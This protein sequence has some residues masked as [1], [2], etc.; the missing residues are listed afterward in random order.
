MVMAL[1][2]PSIILRFYPEISLIKLVDYKVRVLDEKEG[3]YAKVRVM[4]SSS[5]GTESWSTVG[6]SPNIIEASF[7]ALNDS[8]NYKLF[9]YHNS[10]KIVA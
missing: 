4:I 10:K 1:L 7:Q 6:V 3:T 9:K 5:D 2:M 8:I